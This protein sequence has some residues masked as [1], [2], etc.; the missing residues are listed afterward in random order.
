METTSS[1]ISL[2]KLKEQAEINALR[3]LQQQFI[4]ADQL[5]QIDQ[6]YS[7]SEKHKVLNFYSFSL[8]FLKLKKIKIDF[9]S[10]R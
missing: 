5:E 1:S 7:R 8:S 4:T 2:N 6:H 3:R 10:T 9:N